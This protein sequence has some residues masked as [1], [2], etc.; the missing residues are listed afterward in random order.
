MVHQ[1]D[2]GRVGYKDRPEHVV[3]LHKD[4]ILQLHERYRLE[5]TQLQLSNWSGGRDT[6]YRGQDVIVARKS[7]G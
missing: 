7:G 4:R 6:K 2:G 1:V 5:V 3:G